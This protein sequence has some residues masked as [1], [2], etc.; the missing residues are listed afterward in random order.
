MSGRRA[1]HAR[2]AKE[3]N[4]I[5]RKNEMLTNDPIGKPGISG[6]PE[7]MGSVTYIVEP[8]F[9]AGHPMH[10]KSNKGAGS[11]GVYEATFVLAIPGRNVAQTEV[12]FATLLEEGDSLIYL[13]EN[14]EKIEVSLVPDVSD[15]NSIITLNIKINRFNRFAAVSLNIDADSFDSAARA[16][17]DVVMPVLSRWSYQHDIPITT[18]ALQLKEFKS[19]SVWWNTT[20]IPSSRLFGDIEG[21]ST[22]EGRILL[23]AYR[24]GMSSLEPLYKALCMFRVIEGCYVLRS[25]RRSQAAAEQRKFVDPGER[26]DLSQI[27]TENP[28]GRYILEKAF[29][30]YL[31]WK[32]TKLR[33]TFKEDIRHA[34]AH[35]DLDGNPLAA[36]HYDDVLKVENALPVMHHIARSLLAVELN[37]Q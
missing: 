37:Y 6:R 19:G 3:G 30:P 33:D 8:V 21:A 18:S 16:A 25:R 27:S 23:A 28:R 32:F 22:S 1:R 15:E 13:P 20:Q 7:Q 29:A 9:P 17:H 35:L 4:D 36:D 11:R 26:L 31:G 2:K 12:N 14:V 24:E 10:G 34:V 5:V